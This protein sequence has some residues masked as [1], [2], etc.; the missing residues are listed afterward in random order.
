MA[1]QLSHKQESF[2]LCLLYCDCAWKGLMCLVVFKLIKKKKK[3]E[4]KWKGLNINNAV[5]ILC[6]SS[7]LLINYRLIINIIFWNNTSSLKI[8]PHNLFLLV[9]FSGICNVSVKQHHISAENCL[10]AKPILIYKTPTKWCSRGNV[11]F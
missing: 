11:L 6:R 1:T 8:F 5:I 9:A 7:S 4:K 10:A 2:I 3:K